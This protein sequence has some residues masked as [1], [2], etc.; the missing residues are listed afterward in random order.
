MST[1][2]SPVPVPRNQE[3]Q[4]TLNSPA[5]EIHSMEG[6]YLWARWN[7]QDQWA[8]GSH[9]GRMKNDPNF[10]LTTTAKVT[11]LSLPLLPCFLIFSFCMRCFNTPL[12]VQWKHENKMISSQQM[13]L[14]F[15]KDS[16]KKHF[17]SKDNA[18]GYQ[19]NGSERWN[20]FFS[21]V[22]CSFCVARICMRMGPITSSLPLIPRSKGLK[23]T[24][25]LFCPMNA[26]RVQPLSIIEMPFRL[27]RKE[28]RKK[29][30]SPFLLIQLPS[31]LQSHQQ[32]QGTRES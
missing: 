30:F 20:D 16:G 4:T 10:R 14:Y 27:L 21:M 25:S 8:S 31:F 1:P 18:L 23:M 9:V 3:I 12:S 11:L 6:K 15:F 32:H 19:K 26:H 22:A 17:E 13:W 24:L 29:A 7:V 2:Q 5:I 28:K